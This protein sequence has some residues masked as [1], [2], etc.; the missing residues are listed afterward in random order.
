MMTHISHI[1]SLIPCH[2][3]ALPC[4]CSAYLPPDLDLN[5]CLLIPKSNIIK[6]LKYDQGGRQLFYYLFYFSYYYNYL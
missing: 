6:G 3:Y 5:I 2:L 4:P 1:L